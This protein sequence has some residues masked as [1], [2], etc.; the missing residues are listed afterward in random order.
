MLSVFAGLPKEHGI[1]SY[2]AFKQM[3]ITNVNLLHAGFPV[4]AELKLSI[5]PVCRFQ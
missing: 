2:G 4:F 1:A 3:L 5:Y